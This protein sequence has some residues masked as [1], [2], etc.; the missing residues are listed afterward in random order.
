MRP[1]VLTSL[2]GYRRP[3]LGRD[4][5]AGLTVWA[6]LVPEALAYATIAGVS[7][8]VGLYA[9]PAA[10]IF[11]ALLGSSRQ[12][13]V[14]PVSATAAL[15]AATVGEFA[16]HDS[17]KFIA[18]TAA[19]A[20]TTGIA[21]LVAGLARL[22]FLANFISEPVLT[23]FIVGLSLTIIVGQLP[24][25]FGVEKGSGNFFAK[26]W[27]LLTHLGDTSVTT[28]VVGVLSL[29]LLMALKRFA[30]VV[31]AALATLAAGVL[32]VRL[33]HLED[34]GVEIV[35]HIDR[36][37][38]KVHAPDVS[39]GDLADLIGPSLGVLLVGF[40]EGLG[41]AKTYAARGNDAIDANR[42]LIGLGAANV[43]AGMTS[44]MVVG[45][46][47]SKTAVNAG[48]GARSQLSGLV[49]AVLTVLT[50]LLLTGLF[51][52]IPDATLAAVVITAVVALVDVGALVALYRVYTRAL[53]R[54]YGIAARPD[55]IAAI[56]AMLGVLVF[57]TLPGLFLGVAISLAL[58]VY[59]VSWPHVAVLGRVPGARGH[60][61]DLDRH[62]EDVAPAG[63]VVLRVEGGLFFANSE[64]VHT[65]VLASLKRDTQGVVLDAQTMPFVDVTAAR[66]L[67]E[68]ARELDARGIALVVVRDIGQVKDVLRRTDGGQP[69]VQVHATIQ[70]A[71]DSVLR[72]EV[73]SGQRATSRGE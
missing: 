48:A 20:I 50:L 4:L 64:Y 5:I 1:A 65:M 14:G 13:V 11:Y 42:E 58:L 25:L 19:L 68:L 57:G 52:D 30:P 28:L 49:C 18:F 53:G 60:W 34:H 26:L 9:A 22:G 54:L 71:V 17:D 7:P 69:L 47:L 70:E 39:A 8:V 10:L 37:L 24:A 62:P 6:I 63:V 51:E 73:G 16:T 72:G 36:G 67:G 15:S 66:M 21:A 23:G 35:G 43:A 3:W 59:R 31:P 46:S 2:R 44:G 12:L 29:A 55:F 61:V 33:L 41:A 27:D 38:P 32:A 40:A 56:A 45:G